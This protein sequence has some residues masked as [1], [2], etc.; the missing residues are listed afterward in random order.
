MR[1]LGLFDD[2]VLIGENEK[3]QFFETSWTQSLTEEAR[4]MDINGIELRG[5]RVVEAKS[6][7]DSDR[8]FLLID[9]NGK[10]V[11]DCSSV[12]SMS[13]YIRLIKR[14]MTEDNDIVVMAEK[15]NKAKKRKK[16]VK[17]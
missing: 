8:M 14:S 16:K 3:Y 5:Y 9:G 17:K 12:T 6:K 11:Y 10:P 1:K 13:L 15:A 7:E 2:D 4:E